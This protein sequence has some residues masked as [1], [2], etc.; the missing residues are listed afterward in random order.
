MTTIVESVSTDISVLKTEVFDIEFARQL[1]D[2]D[3]ISREEKDKIRR[4]LKN[5][6]KNE[7]QTYYK[8]GKHLKNDYL[9]RLCAVRGESLQ[10]FEKNVR[11]ALASSY[12]WDIDMVN[13]QPTILQ[14]YAEQNGWKTT[15]IQ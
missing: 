9:G 5:S 1:I 13:A 15:A 12:Y 10:T 2:D 3:F 14:Q 4:Y 7:H 8:L 6:I 11:G